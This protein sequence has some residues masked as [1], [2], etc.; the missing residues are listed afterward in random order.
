MKRLIYNKLI[1]WKNRKEHKP[2]ILLGARQVGKTY[3]LKEFGKNEFKNLV[4]VNCHGEDFAKSLFRDLSVQRVKN[5]RYPFSENG[6]IRSLL[7]VQK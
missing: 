1:E 5:G 7:P 4:Y 3:I 6:D 2:L